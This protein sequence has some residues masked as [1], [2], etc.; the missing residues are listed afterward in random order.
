MFDIDKYMHKPFFERECEPHNHCGPMHHEK[1]RFTMTEDVEHAARLMRETIDRLLKFEERVKRECADLAKNLSSDNVIFKNTMHE[2]WTTFLME[3]K[4]EV[5]VFESTVNADLELFKSGIETEYATYKDSVNERLS[6]YVQD[7]ETRMS[8][9]SESIQDQYNSFVEATNARI[10]ANNETVSQALADYQRKLTTELNTF[11]QTMNAQYATF[12]ESVGNSFHEFRETWE[13]II[14][15]RLAAQDGRISD[16]E[17]YMRA[18]LEASLATMIGDMHANGEF[19]DI[20]EGEVFNDLE[21]KS[22]YEYH[23]ATTAQGASVCAEFAKANRRV[24]YVPYGEVLEITET[25]DL[26]GLDVEINGAVKVAFNG[27]GVIVGDVS[28]SSEARRVFIRNVYH[29][30]YKNGDI[31]V[32]VQ[33]CMNADVNI[34]SAKAVQF[35]ADGDSNHSAIAYST[36]HVGKCDIMQITDKADTDNI[37][38]INENTFVNCR[39]M[40]KFSIEGKTYHHNNNV[41]IKP[42]FEGADM[43]LS[44]CQRN[45]FYDL[46]SEGDF[47]LTLGADTAN[48]Y[49]GMNYY[50][51]NFTALA[52]V[53]TD[54][55]VS[56]I[57]TTS[58]LADLDKVMFYNVNAFTLAKNLYEVDGVA[59]MV[60]NE[61]TFTVNAWARFFENKVVPVEGVNALWL[62]TDAKNMRVVVTPLD[63][64]R[65]AMENDPLVYV[66]LKKQGEDGVYNPGANINEAFILIKDPAVKYLNVSVTNGGTQA[67]YRFVTGYAYYAPHNFAKAAVIG[68]YFKN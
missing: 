21:S 49:V 29:S 26:T 16:A 51:D 47:T 23:H 67:D 9:L 68:D 28:N 3:V 45:K 42:C 58:H 32:R 12:T 4:N 1:P 48:N 46:R 43:V 65:V 66:G 40:Q 7:Y 34:G 39:V 44:N 11:E 27:V 41:F 53:V 30:L 17:M 24:F 2:A 31:S 13:Q 14:T 22:K 59:N 56:N 15:E 37:G 61:E 25:L 19:A 6:A 10:D 63:V 60:A 33:G 50:F 20:I 38:W 18:N 5:N 64:N 54:N 35:Y 62:K 52:G 8:A 36:F 57:V 55:G